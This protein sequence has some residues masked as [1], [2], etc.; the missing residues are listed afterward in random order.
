MKNYFTAKRIAK[1]GIFSAMSYVLYLI[2]IPLPFLF[3]SFLKINL[4][5]VPALIG[6]FSM[7]PIAGAIIVIIKVLLK[8]PFSSTMGVGEFSDL[9]NGLAFTLVSSIIY[10]SHKTKKGAVASMAIGSGLSIITSI[11]CNLLIMIPLYLTVMGMTV[12][13]I[14]AAC[15]KAFNVTAENFYI[16]YTFGA[17]LPFNILRCLLASTVTYFLYKS[18]TKLI[19]KIGN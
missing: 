19:N 17:V 14:A 15:P 18:L 7:G 2:N 13:M 3:P 5:D 16:Y 11:L 9:V 6:G 10:K 8:L 4:S 1:I 12:E